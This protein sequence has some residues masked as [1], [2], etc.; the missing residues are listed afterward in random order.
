MTRK[1]SEIQT[2]DDEAH[3]EQ[4]ELAL[5][6]I[7]EAFEGGLLDRAATLIDALA[8]HYGEAD[9][10][11]RFERAALAWE[12]EGPE[13]AVRLLDALLIDFPDYADAHYARALACEEVEDFEGMCRH[14]LEVLRLDAEVDAELGVGG[15]EE[16]DFIEQTAEQV[17]AG[18]PEQ[19]R[20]ALRG[21][22]I[23]LEPRPHRDL[24]AEGFDPRSLGLFEG[25]EH[26]NQAGGDHVAP[27]RIV[28]FH[29]NLLADYPDPEDL[30]EEIEI[31]LLHE[32]GH[33]FGLDEDDVERLGLA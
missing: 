7:H 28:L 12:R 11:V 31:T 33:F 6:D 17:I 32:I 4:L 18:V 5:A 2:I 23:V 27:T 14:F 9:P 19:F 21:V 10:S 13:S 8:E 16:L 22:P 26:A 29:A 25:L 30:A 1:P 15:E 3:D 24:V 20:D